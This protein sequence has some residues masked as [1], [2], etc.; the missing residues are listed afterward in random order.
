MLCLGGLESANFGGKRLN[1]EAQSAIEIVDSLAEVSPQAWNALAGAQPFLRHEFLRALETTGCVGGRTGWLPQHLLLRR[2]SELKAALPLYIKH[3]SYGEYVF[4]WAWADAYTRHGLRYYP[5]LLTAVPFTPVTGTRLLGDSRDD[6]GS[7]ARAAIELAQG[8][9]ASS[10]HCLFPSEGE[11]QELAE[12]GLLLRHGVQFHWRNEGY[13]G[14]DAYLNAM[15]HDKRKKIKQERRKVRD[16]GVVFE[17]KVGPEIAEADWEF[18]ERCYRGTYRAHHSTPYLNLAFF[19][20][21][22]RQLGEQVLLVIGRQQGEPIAAAFNLFDDAALY[23][24]YWG[25]TTFVPGMHFEACYYQAI[26]FCIARGISRFEGG[27]QGEHK[28]ARGLLPVKTY[29]AHWL[30]HPEFGQA[31][32]RFLAHEAEGVA[33]YVDE[34]NERN[35]FKA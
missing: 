14:F 17:H 27:A 32:E 6:R 4:D 34:L 5:K 13:A 12:Q 33:D 1:K 24:R 31:I 3:H 19:E 22:G 28:L 8:L 35:P 29:S 20:E 15:S 18:F 2:G 10:W 21:L 16:A 11:A 23:G 25:A 7:L 9:G 26:E 30:A